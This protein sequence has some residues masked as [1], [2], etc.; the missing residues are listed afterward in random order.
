[1]AVGDIYLHAQYYRNAITQQWMSKY[2]LVLA[3]SPSGDIVFRLLTS[4]PHGRPNNPP[5]YHGDPVAG[6]YLGVLGGSLNKPTW[7]DLHPHKDMDGDDFAQKITEGVISFCRT[8]PIGMLCPA[9]SC[10]AN[11]PDTTNAQYGLMLN[12]RHALGCT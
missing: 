10:A 6:Y 4:Q 9:I 5:C 8:L 7:L 3:I 2:F 11:A 1:M 12:A